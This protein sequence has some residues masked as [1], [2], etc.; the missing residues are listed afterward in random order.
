MAITN[1]TEDDIRAFCNRTGQ[2]LPKGLGA[3][4]P[5]RANKYHNTKTEQDG[6]MYD[7][8][9]E[10][11]RAR[12]LQLMQAAGEIVSFAEQ[13]PFLLPGGIRYIADFVVL[14]QDGTYRVEDSKGA[15]T[16]GYKLKKRLMRECKGIEIVEV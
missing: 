11:G 7:S 12:E 10:A 8:K 4:R 5:K 1:F 16:E 15:R 9:R 13:V 3:A 14:L 2:P 6:K